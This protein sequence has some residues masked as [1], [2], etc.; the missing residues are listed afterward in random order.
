[1]GLLLSLLGAVGVAPVVAQAD[2]PSPPGATVKLVFIHHSTGE[3][4]LR[5]GYGDLGIVLGQNNYFVS[6]TNY[7]WGPDAIGD[8]TD[9]PNWPEWFRGPESPRYLEAL[10]R[11][12][13]QN[14]EYTR[15]LPDPGGENQ[16]VLFKSCFP[17]SSLEGNPDDPPAPGDGLTVSNAKYIYNDLLNYFITR[18]DRLFIVITA[19]PLIDSTYA[20]N[21]RAFNIWLT[22]DW[23]RENNYPYNN[24]AVFDF[25]N[26]LTHPDNHHRFIDGRVEYVAD[27]GDG[28]AYYPTEDDHPSAE[29]SHKATAEFVP[30]LNVFY[31]RWKVGAPVETPEAPVQAPV[32]TSPPQG[33]TP[34]ALLPAPTTGLIDDFE[35]GVPSGSDGWNPYWDEATQ[36][37]IACAVEGGMAHGGSTALH[38]HFNVQADS[39]ATCAT[40]YEQPRD[41]RSAGGLSLYV[42]AVQPAQ[43][44][45]VIVY[46]S[47]ADNRATYQFSVETTQEMVDGWAHLELP[48][49]LLRRADWEADAG[50]P[51]V[52]GQVVGMAFGFDTFPATPNEGEI[53]VD[54]IELM[55][56]VNL[57]VQPTEAQQQPAE[58]QAAVAEAPEQGEP[59]QP[60]PTEAGSQGGGGICPGSA[61]LAL[62][63]ALGAV[64]A[65]RRAGRRM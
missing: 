2:D 54:D 64:W 56:A 37:Q 41:W 3:N 22:Q 20:A 61:G 13:G 30:L 23:L 27:N 57:G 10:F 8:R 35:A 16:I 33:E 43:V 32:V 6:D 39:W 40:F 46:T 58:T 29:G 17:N 59:T 62:L 47:P 50:T 38:P 36:T 24:V 44:F 55:G 11:E 21:A 7:G 4:W 14:S 48:W 15:N 60:A 34:V 5:D 52:P 1:L 28:T 31:H 65:G 49:E 63:A 53:W 26:L 9:I 45:D 25:H 51:L 42:H 18:P 12:S 19:P